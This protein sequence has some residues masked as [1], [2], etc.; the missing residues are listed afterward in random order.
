MLTSHEIIVS[1]GTKLQEIPR[2][3]LNSG[4]RY[5]IHIK[6]NLIDIIRMVKSIRPNRIVDGRLTQDLAFAFNERGKL[7]IVNRRVG[8]HR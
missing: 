7:S 1:R 2:I 8:S 6:S 5:G 3:V 4:D